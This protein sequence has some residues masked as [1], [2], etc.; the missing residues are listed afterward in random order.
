M[1][2]K[3]GTEEAGSERRSDPRSVCGG[4]SSAGALHHDSPC[5]YDD[6]SVPFLAEGGR[7]VPSGTVGP[8]LWSR[9]PRLQLH[10]FPL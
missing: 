10:P 6:R 8:A 7:T 4:L 9:E 2:P 3:A 1:N 5:I